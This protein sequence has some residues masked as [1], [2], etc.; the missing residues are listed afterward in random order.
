ME[1]T[2]TKKLGLKE[3][4]SF[5]VGMVIGS[6]VFFKATTVFK[7]SNNVTTGILAWILGGIITICA[8]LTIA[9]IASA[10]PKTGGL[11]VYL[12]ELYGEKIGFLFGWVQ[13]TISSPGT[14]AACAIILIDQL[15]SLLPI[16]HTY[17]K[18]F[19]VTLIFCLAFV[20]I[21]ASKAVGKMQILVTIGKLIP[22]LL[23]IGFA[24]F[25]NNSLRSVATVSIA[26][27]TVSGFGSALLATLWAYDGWIGVATLAGEIDNPRKNVPR[28]ILIGLSIVISVYVLFNF[29]LSRV[30]PFEMLI[31]SEKVA[32]DAATVLFGDIASTFIALGILVSVFGAL[33]G[34]YMAGSRV[35]YAM[36]E[37]NLFPF[38]DK[39]TK[40]Y[41]KDV[42]PIYSL[43]V[44][45]TMGIM[46]IVTGSFE[47]L[48]EL[49]IFSLWIFFLLGIFGVFIL[50]NKRP[51]LQ[52]TYKVPFYP[53]VPLI[54]LIG[55]GFVLVN[56]LITSPTNAITGV[57]IT[58]L[59]FPVYFMVKR[60]EKVVKIKNKILF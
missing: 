59:G 29:A 18:I 8:G 32:E 41:G 12:K 60:K 30:L 49:V 43:I 3:G 4:I 13:V 23:I 50:R 25:K 48:T 20:N 55:G 47:M 52:G 38:K 56:T 54:G 28:A 1:K 2:L 57:I 40:V 7:S 21:F 16:G 51:D 46:Y 5:V 15:S 27:T 17:I 6:G 34:E 58:L 39:L 35:P 14:V 24:L 44:S 10:I 26:H 22:L 45:S 9:E 42:I 37:N 11:F 53:I 31:A 19:A 36:A 33:N